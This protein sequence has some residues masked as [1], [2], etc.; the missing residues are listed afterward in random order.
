MR[1]RPRRA[2]AGAPSGPG[3]GRRS[4]P[5]P[6]KHDISISLIY[7]IITSRRHVFGKKKTARLPCR[8]FDLVSGPLLGTRGLLTSCG[9]WR[10]ESSCVPPALVSSSCVPPAGRRGWGNALAWRRR[11]GLRPSSSARIPSSALLEKA[12]PR[13]VG[14]NVCLFSNLNFR[15]GQ[16]KVAVGTNSL[17]E[18][19]PDCQK[20]QGR[21]VS[22]R[23]GPSTPSHRRLWRSPGPRCR[24]G[25]QP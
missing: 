22:R 11:C 20:E 2:D 18:S 23:S 14:C 7:D 25:A 21:V 6:P 8:G 9:A 16:G 15:Q 19:S 10:A 12:I 5:C 1:I 3:S 4:S 24:P 13:L 17:G